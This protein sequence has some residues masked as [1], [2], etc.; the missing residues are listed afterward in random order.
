MTEVVVNP[1]CP[2]SQTS[3]KLIEELEKDSEQH[4]YL[5]Y[6][7]DFQKYIENPLQIIY[8][9]VIAQLNGG[10]TKRLNIVPNITNQGSQYNLYQRNSEIEVD[11]AF[12]FIHF[13]S[14]EFRFGLFIYEKSNDK[15]R[16]IKN[17]QNNQAKE[18]LF[19]NT[20]LPDECI[21]H[22]SS[23]KDLDRINLLRD[24]LRLVARQN[25]VTKNI[26]VSVHIKANQVLLCSCEDLVNQ[27][28]RTFE[29]IFP[30]FLM[31]VSDEPIKEIR[32]CLDPE[33]KSLAQNYYERGLRKYKEK[34]YQIAI[35]NFDTCIKISPNLAN[36]YKYRGEAKAELGNI[37]SA[38]LDYSQLLLIQPKNSEIYQRRGYIYYKLQDYEKAIIDYNQSIRTNPNFALAYYQRGLAYLKLENQQKAFEDLRTAVELFDKEK[39]VDNYEEAQ[40]ILKTIQPGYSEPSLSEI[41]QNISCKGLRISESILRRYHLALKIRKFVILSGASGT[42]KTWLTKAYAEIVGAEYLSIA[43]APNWTTNEDLLGYLNPLEKGVYHYTAFS[44]FLEE[45]A[46]EYKQAETEK[47]TSRPYHLVLDEM[48]L[49]RVEYYF[50]KFL[51]AME[52]RMREGV[53]EIELASEKQVILPPNLYFIGTVNVD[54]TTHGFADK[55]YDRAQMIELEVCREDLSEHLDKVDY[56]EILMQIWDKLHVVAPFAFRVMDEIKTYV[57]EAEALDVEWQEALDEQ[58]LQKILPKLKGADERVG[59]AL[60]A[61]VNIAEENKFLLSYAK[62]SKMLKTFEQHGFTS[63]F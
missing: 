40:R 9:H 16:L 4:F 12:L 8:S 44:H 14:E 20:H 28:K 49:A 17:T 41:I 61:F 56:R 21:L 50:A 7:E 58:L 45:A 33:H 25:S 60:K 30:L 2:F 26:Q 55:V 34:N 31:A 47:R 19:Q 62:A 43:V 23:Q 22:N 39:D 57:K 54:E 1:E 3:F 29:G 35:I 27:I 46:E 42:G 38:L 48:N 32:D 52:V 24:W 53:A 18:I 51:S 59:E 13:T 5:A 10:I 15:V 6:K 11:G 37:D 63:Y 36:A